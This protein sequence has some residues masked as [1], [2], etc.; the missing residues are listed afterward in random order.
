MDD[1][2]LE[3]RARFLVDQAVSYAMNAKE[4][5]YPDGH[6][7]YDLFAGLVADALVETFLKPILN[8]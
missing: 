6:L 3:K 5:W 2:A 7:D 1:D 8:H 4:S